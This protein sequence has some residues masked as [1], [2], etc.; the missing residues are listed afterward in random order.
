M[1]E[2]TE[3]LSWTDTSDGTDSGYDEELISTAPITT[4]IY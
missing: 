4:S 1:A 2:G 3:A